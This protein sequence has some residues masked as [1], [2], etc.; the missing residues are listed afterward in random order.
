D[1]CFIKSMKSDAVNHDPAMTFM[2]TGA[3]LPERP[4][5]GAWVTYGLGSENANLPGF[6]VLM[7]KGGYDQPLSSKLWDSG[8]LPSQYQG[9][10]SR[11]AKDAVLF[12]SNP[13]GTGAP[14]TRRVLDAMQSLAKLKAGPEAEIHARMEQFEMA[15]RMQ[16]SVPGITELRGEPDHIF[17]LYGPQ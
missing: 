11:A 10:Q 2:H 14:D 8:F 15:F 17:D 9:T 6:V 12:L 13:S 4:S 16:S 5:M 7:S 3:Q 1:I